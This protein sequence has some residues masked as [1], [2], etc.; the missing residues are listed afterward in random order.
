MSRGQKGNTMA[1]E[2]R[3]VVQEGDETKLDAVTSCFMLGLAKGTRSRVIGGSDDCVGTVASLYL[4]MLG[5]ITEHQDQ[6]PE[7]RE[8]INALNALKGIIEGADDD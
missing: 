2:W 6:H 5:K 8:A 1:K 3:I 4:H 7:L